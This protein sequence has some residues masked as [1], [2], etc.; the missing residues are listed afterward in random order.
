MSLTGGGLYVEGLGIE[1]RVFVVVMHSVLT[2]LSI[3]LLKD[4]LRRESPDV[5]W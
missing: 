5:L 2:E 3:F 1:C 4:F